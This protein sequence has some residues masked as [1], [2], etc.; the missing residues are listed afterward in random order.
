M[1]FIRIIVSGDQGGRWE[2]NVRRDLSDIYNEV[3]NW[4]DQAP[5]RV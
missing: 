2:D 3:G 4:V 5:D 1:Y